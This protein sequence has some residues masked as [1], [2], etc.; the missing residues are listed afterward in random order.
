MFRYKTEESLTG[1]TA[2]MTFLTEC[3]ENAETPDDELSGHNVSE[4]ECYCFYHS[5]ADKCPVCVSHHDTRIIRSIRHNRV[6]CL[7]I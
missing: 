2:W 5:T 1:R 6:I 7:A 3:M 4:G